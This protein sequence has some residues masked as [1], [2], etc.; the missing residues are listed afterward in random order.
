MEKVVLGEFPRHLPGSLVDDANWDCRGSDSGLWCTY[1]IDGVTY[2]QR[3]SFKNAKANR[4][5]SEPFS[6]LWLIK[7]CYCVMVEVLDSEW[8][9]ELMNGGDQVVSK[10]YQLRHF[11]VYIEDIGAFEVAAEDIVWGPEEVVQ[12]SDESS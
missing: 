12:I 7:D 4:W 3:V 5:T 10:W 9:R 1:W 11:M 8:V 2:T 6:Q